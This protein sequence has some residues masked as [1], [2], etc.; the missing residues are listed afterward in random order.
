MT[1]SI[2][3][4]AVLGVVTFVVGMLLM[5]P[6]RFVYDRFAP[7]AVALAGIAG[8]LWSGSAADGRIGGVYARHIR[9][10]MRPLHLVTGK[11][12][13]HVEASP[14]SNPVTGDVAIT[15]GGDVVVS[16]FRGSIPLAMLEDAL[17]IRGL[18][19]SASIDLRQLRLEDGVP[20]S[21]SGSVEVSGLIAP[22]PAPTPIGGYR[23]E[24]FTQQ[25]GINASVEDTDGVLDLAGQALLRADRSYQFRGMIAPK[26]STP[27]QLASQLRFLGSPNERGQY[28]LRLEGSL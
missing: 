19:G 22:L 16:D 20:A 4:L 17:G 25:D 3:R 26:P 27:P 7:P 10:R 1:P 12:A 28:E 6:A 14:S 13:F 21:A 8:S 24:F 2:R 9:W 15:A 11:L 18:G 5:I 23:A